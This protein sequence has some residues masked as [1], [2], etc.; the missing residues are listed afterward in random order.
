MGF[1]KPKKEE[2]KAPTVVTVPTSKTEL[3]KRVEAI[4]NAIDKEHSTTNSIMRLG[5]RVGLAVPC[6]PSNLITFDYETLG[7]GGLP[8]GRIIEIY[9]PESS[10]KTTICLH[11]VAEEQAAGGTVAFV[12]A[13]HALD[14]NYAHQLNVDVENLLISQPNNGEQALSVVEKLVQDKC[15]SLIV[16]DSVAALVPKAELEGEMG[17]AAVGLHARLMSQAMRKLIG[18]TE[19]NGVTIIFTNQIR[20]KIGI[21]FGNPETTTG[22]RAL[23]FYASIRL[24]VRRKDAIK[25]GDRLVGHKILVKAVKNKMATPYRECTLDLYYPDSEYPAGLDKAGSLLEY[26]ELR[27]KVDRSGSWYSFNDERIGQGA[28]NAKATVRDNEGI[29]EAMQKLAVSLIELDRKAQTAKV[30]V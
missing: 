23:K 21:M 16:V 10:G 26:L 18:V 3:F 13:E 20:E 27:G 2:K 25:V 19:K 9:G 1:Y 8:R 30:K 24:D 28:D 22:G 29:R 17:E 14:P 6:I 4:S 7:C 15:A 12:D 5:S 11:F